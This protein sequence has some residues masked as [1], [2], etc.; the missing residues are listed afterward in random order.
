[1]S[2]AALVLNSATRA[3]G[4]AEA[5]LDGVDPARAARFAQGTNGPIHANHAVFVYGHLSLYYARLIA[6]LG[7]DASA[8]AVPE[9]YQD[10]FKHG[11]ECVDDAD[12]SVYPP[13]EE[14]AGHVKRGWEAA[15]AVVKACSDEQLDAE[16]PDD[17][18]RAM[19]P[20]VGDIANFLLNDHVMFHLGQMST[21]RRAEGLGSVM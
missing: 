15:V 14:L 9:H 13:L 11:A 20:T 3:H 19:F 8:A 17:N 21:W 6:M 10:L 4:L 1:M 18:F 2:K 5:L 7:Q 16:T 12:G